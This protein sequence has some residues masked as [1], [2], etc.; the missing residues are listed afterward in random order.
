MQN[1]HKAQAKRQPPFQPSTPKPFSYTSPTPQRVAREADAPEELVIDREPSSV[2]QSNDRGLERRQHAGL[3]KCCGEV[4]APARV[5]RALTIDAASETDL[6]HIATNTGRAQRGLPCKAR[7]DS[8]HKQRA[9]SQSVSHG[10][11][12]SSRTQLPAYTI[13]RAQLAVQSEARFAAQAA[14]GI[15]IC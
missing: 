3:P 13:Q 5:A 4:C 11:S 10:A 2:M 12:R 9:A 6:A 1:R 15:A 14:S 8:Q 7:R